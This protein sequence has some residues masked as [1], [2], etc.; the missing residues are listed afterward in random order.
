ML[1]IVSIGGYMVKY[2]IEWIKNRLIAD[3]MASPEDLNLFTLLDDPEKIVQKVID[4][5]RP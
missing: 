4:F 2:L 3:K 5:K 1:L